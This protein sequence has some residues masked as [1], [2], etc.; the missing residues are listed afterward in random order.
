M[1]QP[2]AYV[3]K[4]FGDDKK[5]GRNTDKSNM[6]MKK[7]ANTKMPAVE[8]TNSLLENKKRKSALK[9]MVIIYFFCQ[10]L[11]TFC[12]MMYLLFGYSCIIVCFSA[13]PIMCLFLSHL[14][15]TDLSPPSSQ[16]TTHPPPN[17]FV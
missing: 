1:I 3:W 7:E 15:A 6:K 16:Q 5:K 9:L 13:A 2:T 17:L 4:R 12:L 8:T 14:P 11:N 10:D